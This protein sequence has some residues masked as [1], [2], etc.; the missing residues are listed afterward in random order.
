MKKINMSKCVVA[1]LPIHT[2]CF[3]LHSKVFKNAVSSNK[4]R[5]RRLDIRILQLFID[6]RHPNYGDADEN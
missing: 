6:A 4:F 5:I 2:L 1:Q 3:L